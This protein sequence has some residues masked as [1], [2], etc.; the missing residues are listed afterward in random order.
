MKYPEFGINQV[1]TL[2]ISQYNKNLVNLKTGTLVPVR[3][4]RRESKIETEEGDFPGLDYSLTR[5]IMAEEPT[6]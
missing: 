3:T 1:S 5:S 6:G 2:F 4:I